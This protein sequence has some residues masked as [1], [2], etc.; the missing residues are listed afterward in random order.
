VPFFSIAV[1]P[2]DGQPRLIKRHHFQNGTFSL[3]D[4]TAGDL[5]LRISSTGFVPYELHIRTS[6]AYP[7]QARVFV[8]ESLEQ[9]FP[10]LKE[11]EQNGELAGCNATEEDLAPGGTDYLRALSLARHGK[12][13]DAVER[14]GGQFRYCRNCTPVLA[15]L[16]LIFYVL[17][18]P[19]EALEYATGSDQLS[20]S[21]PRTRLSLVKMY[22]RLGQYNQAFELLRT[23]SSCVPSGIKAQMAAEIHF[24]LKQY[25]E[26]KR[27]IELALQQQPT[28]IVAWAIYTNIAA[29]TGDT[30]GFQHGLRE[31]ERLAANTP[32]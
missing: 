18:F 28:S 26:A 19:R 7:G 3:S 10:A 16:G 20:H 32:H 27:D 22:S 12:L 1:V 21:G 29:E 14:Y 8:L 24:Q 6:A 23:V 13:D 17:G 31:L 11:F 4:M 15:D 9:A 30:T 2:A 25:E 5:A